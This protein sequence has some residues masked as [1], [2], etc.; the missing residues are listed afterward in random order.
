MFKSLILKKKNIILHPSVTR[1]LSTLIVVRSFVV[2]SSL[3][4]LSRE[5]DELPQNPFKTLSII[6][7]NVM[8]PFPQK[9]LQNPPSAQP[10]LSLQPPSLS[11]LLPTSPPSNPLSKPFHYLFNNPLQPIH[12]LVANLSKPLQNPF[13]NQL[14]NLP[15]NSITKPFRKHQTNAPFQ[16]VF[17]KLRTSL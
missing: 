15:S 6:L 1:A 16:I 4:S 17:Q 5:P 12:C 9:P 11:S 3:L 8:T 2:P 7:Q 13:R 14:E 10:P